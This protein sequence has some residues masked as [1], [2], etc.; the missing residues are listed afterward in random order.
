MKYDEITKHID[1]I[2]S[3]AMK[4]CDNSYDAED[5]ASETILSAI[6]YL[7]SGGVIEN[8]KSYLLTIL[9]RKYYSL[10]RK[11]YKLPTTAIAD[12]FDIIDNDDFVE[13]LI[14]EQDREAIRREV[15]YLSKSY[16]EIIVKHYFYGESVIDIAKDFGLSE[17][18]VKSRLDFGRKQIKKGFED[19]KSYTEN[20]YMPQKLIL[21]NSGRLGLND[22]PMSLCDD[23]NTLAQNLLILAYERPISIS[24][25]SKEIGVATAYCEPIVKKLLDGELMEQMGDGKVYTDFIIYHAE[26]YVKYIKEQEAFAEK[27]IEAYLEPVKEAINELKKTDF[28]SLPLERY[29]LIHIACEGL[30]LCDR[31]LPPQIF[32]DR[33]NGGKWIAF[34]TVYPYNY[35]IPED[36]KGKEEYLM[37][38]QRWTRLE[39]YLDK[40]DL[41]FYNY[42]TSLYPCESKFAEGF[43]SIQENESNM[44]KLFC[45]IKNKISPS[46]VDLDERIIKAIPLFKENGFIEEKNGELSLKVACINHEEEKT[47]W[48]ICEKAAQKF[49]IRIE[50]PML[51]YY[52]THR[53]QVP[54][55]LKSVSEQKL[56][57]PYSPGAMMFVYEAIGKGVHP[58]D[59]GYPCPESIIV[60]D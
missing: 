46:A 49:A 21:R 28:Y 17:G 54:Q 11:K 6:M 14:N 18:T 9:N 26:D 33:P 60:I 32:P 40:Y 31:T 2:L 15:A 34:G 50:K 27:Y 12:G 8:P 59:L 56:L 44:L 7:E 41:C 23:E 53:K 37:S 57:M 3:Y 51:D 4:K 39:N 16:R 42:E 10:L 38:G 20:S 47:F 35:K 19:M 24:D 43:A 13:N 5:L 55:H 29:M 1:Y 36:K 48:N 22:E 45:L 30:R 52:K 58:R 25:L